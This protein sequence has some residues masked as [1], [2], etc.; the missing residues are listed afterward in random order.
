M[1]ERKMEHLKAINLI[2]EKNIRKTEN[3][4][5]ERDRDRETD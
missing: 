1:K 2:T 5:G 3:A 4:R